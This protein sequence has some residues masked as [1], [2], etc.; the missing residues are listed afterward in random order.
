MPPA[1]VQWNAWVAGPVELK[2]T[3]TNPSAETLLA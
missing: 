2:P 1:L 3:T